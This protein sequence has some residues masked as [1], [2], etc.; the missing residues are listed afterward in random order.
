M[1]TKRI[2]K[3]M[4]KERIQLWVDAL[5]SGKYKQG[6]F[7]LCVDDKYC[8]LGVMCEV[9]IDGGVNITKENTVDAGLGCEVTTYNGKAA[10]LPPDVFRWFGLYD[11]SPEVTVK[12]G[13]GIKELNGSF[14]EYE[15]N[16]WDYPLTDLNDDLCATF[17]QIADLIEAEWLKEESDA[18]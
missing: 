5:R 3:E 6:Q 16:G 4:N 11:S 17:E 14:D 10:L 7:R 13:H 8:C 18:A 2:R 9:A 1:D 12:P 15:A